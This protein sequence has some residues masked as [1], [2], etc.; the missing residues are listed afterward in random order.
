[1][2]GYET[3]PQ[4]GRFKAWKSGAYNLA[5]RPAGER[6]GA[7]FSAK[8]IW[9]SNLIHRF[10]D[11]EGERGRQFIFSMNIIQRMQKIEIHIFRI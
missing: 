8:K 11:I 3:N 9:V 6:E 4:S 1:M 7:S 5:T 2:G 10:C